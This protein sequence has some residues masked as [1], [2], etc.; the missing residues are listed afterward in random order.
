MFQIS[1][2][3]LNYQIIFKA[4]LITVIHLHKQGENIAASAKKLCAA[5]MTVHQTVKQY[6][7]L[8]TVDDHPRSGRSRSQNGTFQPEWAP[9]HGAKTIAELCRQ[10]F[11]DV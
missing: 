10:Q 2:N 4:P 3:S 11:L 1:C 6:Q 8:G 7:R 5:R 9:T